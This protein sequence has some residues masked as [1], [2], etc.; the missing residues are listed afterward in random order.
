M[1]P[2]QPKTDPGRHRPLCPQLSLSGRPLPLCVFGARS[3][4]GPNPNPNRTPNRDPPQ[5][6]KP[7]S[8]LNP[9]TEHPPRPGLSLTMAHHG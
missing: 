7:A 9:A 4:M 3:L 6:V 2:W 8:I 1:W 5:K